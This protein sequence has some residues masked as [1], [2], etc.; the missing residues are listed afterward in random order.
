MTYE[1]TIKL[2]GSAAMAYPSMHDKDLPALA[3]SWYP[4]LADLDCGTV[5]IAM[6]QLVATSKF[7]PSVAEVRERALSLAHPS[8]PDAEAAWAEVLRQMR[9]TG[10][11]R[12]PQWSDP[13]IGEAVDAAWGSWPDACRSVMQ[14]TLGV[15]RAHFIRI[16][17]SLTK[18]R[19]EATL[20]PPGSS[21]EQARRLLVQQMKS[22]PGGDR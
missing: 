12:T 2:I 5:E 14:E 8:L 20:L 1:D 21:V 18:T 11:A 4:M 15:D 19:R 3:R 13:A 16:Y 6:M 9:Y 17:E 10:W 7:M 22:L